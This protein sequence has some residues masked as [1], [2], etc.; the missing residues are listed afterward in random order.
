MSWE[1]WNVF[2]EDCAELAIGGPPCIDCLH[3]KPQRKYVDS[4]VGLYYDG[5]VCCHNPTQERDFSCY[6]PRRESP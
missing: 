1:P 6:M 4:P 2:E 5:V 3:W